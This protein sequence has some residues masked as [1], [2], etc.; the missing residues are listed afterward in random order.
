MSFMNEFF[1]S[2]FRTLGRVA[3]YIIIGLIIYFICSNFVDAQMIKEGNVSNKDNTTVYSAN[4]F[5]QLTYSGIW[6]Y[7]SLYYDIT[8]S[9]GQ[10]ILFSTNYQVVTNNINVSRISMAIWY[11]GSDNSWNQIIDY[12]SR[13][14]TRT[15]GQSSTWNVS[16]VCNIPTTKNFKQIAVSINMVDSSGNNMNTPYLRF[17]QKSNSISVSGTSNEDIG[18]SINNNNDKNTTEIINNNDENT[19]KII[20]NQ[21][22]NNQELKDAIAN[23]FDVCTTYNYDINTFPI[24]RENVYLNGF[25]GDITENN[26]WDITDYIIMNDGLNYIV[27]NNI[28]SNITPGFCL[29]DND[30]NLTSCQNYRD[31]TYTILG[32]NNSRY[33]RISVPKTS[34]RQ[35]YFTGDYC[36]NVLDE[37]LQATENV[38]EGLQNVAD[39]LSGEHEPTYDFFDD[40]GLSDDTPVTNLLLIPITLLSAFNSGVSGTCQPVS[41]GTLYGTELVLPCINLE[42]RLGSDLWAIIDDITAIF[43]IYEIVMLVIASFEG[44]SSLN[45]C[46]DLLY[47]PKHGNLTREGRGHSAGLY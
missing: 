12:C 15:D 10:S 46:F 33:V 14:G 1:K 37:Q 17:I 44:L 23:Q 31:A 43:I 22:K 42:Q 21:N 4:N 3:A 36:Y 16:I 13:S 2:I 9:N 5:T 34:G 26:A 45:D 47:E 39:I 41:L 8:G 28:S 32:S 38:S 20:D 6:S 19:E 35:V 18:N 11:I 27:T 7:M 30:K 24:T 25:N 40:I 29:Y